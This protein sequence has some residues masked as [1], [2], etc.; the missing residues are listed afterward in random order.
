MNGIEVDN[1]P[2]PIPDFDGASIEVLLG[3]LD[4]RLIIGTFEYL[5]WFC[6]TPVS[7]SE[8]DAIF[9]HVSTSCMIYRSP[10]L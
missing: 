8:K 10:N 6:D 4:S 7:V 3:L 1:P 2:S 9:L 5:G